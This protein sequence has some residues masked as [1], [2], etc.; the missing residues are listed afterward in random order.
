MNGEWRCDGKD[1]KIKKSICATHVVYSGVS[2][3][4]GQHCLCKCST[5]KDASVDE[6]EE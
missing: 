2:Y 3:M 1:E 6:I 4:G 5:Q